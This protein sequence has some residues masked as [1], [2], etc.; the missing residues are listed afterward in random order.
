MKLKYL[1]KKNVDWLFDEASTAQGVYHGDECEEGRALLDE[2][3]KEML[4]A[5]EL[6]KAGEHRDKVVVSQF[7]RRR[8]LKEVS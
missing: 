4:G 8:G 5:L 3:R 6:V 7:L 1:T 2:M